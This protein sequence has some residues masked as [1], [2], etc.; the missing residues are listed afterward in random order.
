MERTPFQIKLEAHEGQVRSSYHQLR[1]FST[2]LGSGLPKELHGWCLVSPETGNNINSLELLA[3][4]LA[5]KT[6]LKD[7][8][9]ISVFLQVDNTT[10]VAYINNNG[11]HSVKPAD[12]TDMES[13][14]DSPRQIRPD[15]LPSSLLNHHG[16]IQ[17]TGCG[18]VCIQIDTLDT[19]LLQLKTRPW[20][21]Q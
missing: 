17:T 12:I 18:S 6:F 21:K 9:G 4:M 1:Y 14:T 8:S 11:R 2:R 19:P 3:A 16:S 7:V 13:Q 20:C 10:A 15:A 5:A